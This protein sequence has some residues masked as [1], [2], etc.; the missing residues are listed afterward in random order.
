MGLRVG[1][2]SR[3]FAGQ[4]YQSDYGLPSTGSCGSSY[5]TQST[6]HIQRESTEQERR[7]CSTVLVSPDGK[8][9]PVLR[10]RYKK[11]RDSLWQRNDNA[12]VLI[13]KPG[14]VHGWVFG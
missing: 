10:Y 7:L 4:P 14:T 1:G 12:C 5:R 3:R 8:D 6:G 2:Y 13:G 9:S 11:N